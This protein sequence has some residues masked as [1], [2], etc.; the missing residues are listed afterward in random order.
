MSCNEPL[1]LKL[2]PNKS[3]GINVYIS[4]LCKY[5]HILFLW[6]ESYGE[7]PEIG[8]PINTRLGI[9]RRCLPGERLEESW[10]VLHSEELKTI[11]DRLPGHS[12]FFM[13]VQR[14]PKRS[15]ALI[16][17]CIRLYTLPIRHKVQIVLIKTY[18]HESINIEVFRRISHNPSRY[19]VSKWNKSLV[20]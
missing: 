12:S 17:N 9:S 11:S 2:C 5:V 16:E 4:C 18:I 15:L 14:A 10:S 7:L 3:T 1:S 20:V 6:Q 19:C 13:S 8:F